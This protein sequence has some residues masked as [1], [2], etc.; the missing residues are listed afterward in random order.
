[1]KISKAIFV[2][3]ACLGGLVLGLRSCYSQVGIPSNIEAERVAPQAKI[4]VPQVPISPDFV[5]YF[6]EP[7]ASDIKPGQNYPLVHL[8]IPKKPH[9][10]PNAKSGPVRTYGATLRMIWPDLAGLGEPGGASCLERY[11]NGPGGFCTNQV[12]VYIDFKLNQ[13]RSAQDF[14][15]RTLENALQQGWL[16]PT[17]EKSTVPSLEMV[18]SDTKAPRSETEDYRRLHLIYRDASGK[19]A[20][21][22]MCKPYVPSPSCETRFTSEK[23]PYIVIKILFV[24]SLLPQWQ[25]VVQAVQAKVSSYIVQTYQ[26]PTQTPTKE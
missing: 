10:E 16:H 22:I 6:L 2:V 12:E 25:Q 18:A 4:Q 8:R 26:L 17:N 24:Y 11:R 1:M 19:P 15:L 5:E 7:R 23:S 14:E 20:A 9:F 3:A 21:T 13:E